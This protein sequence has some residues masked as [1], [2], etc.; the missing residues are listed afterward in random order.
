MKY[1]ITIL[2]Y[3]IS[4]LSFAQ[5]KSIKEVSDKVIKLNKAIFIDKDSLALEILLAYEINYGH[6][7]GKVENR[8]E[9]INNNTSESKFIALV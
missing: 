8:K 1:L 4:V 7:G 6:S 2:F 3:F 9:M 5:Y